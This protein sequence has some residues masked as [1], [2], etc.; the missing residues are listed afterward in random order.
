[1]IKR[2]LLVIGCLAAF[3]SSSAHAVYFPAGIDWANPSQNRFIL[4]IYLNMLG[5]APQEREISNA[6]RFLSPNDNSQARLDLFKELL[7][8]REYQQIFGAQ[9]N[10]WKVYR[11]PDKNYNNGNGYWRYLSA[12]SRPSG[13]ENWRLSGSS[14][15]SVA[16]SMAHYYD[17]F[18]YQGTPCIIDPKLAYKRGNSEYATARPVAHACADESRLV[19]QFEWVANNGTTYPRGTDGTTL[20]M[21]QHYFKAEGTVLQ[22][23]QCDSGYMN[24]QRDEARDIR[25]QR[26]GRDSNG[27]PTLFFA[28]G[29]RL[30]L[31]SHN[32]ATG[33]DQTR[34]ENSI[35]QE[36]VLVDS[37]RNGQHSCADPAVANSK[38]R[39][40]STNGTSESNGIGSST[41]CMDNFYYQIEGTNLKRFDCATGFRGCRANPSKDI[42]AEKRKRVE[43]FPGLEF[44]NGTTLALIK[45]GAAGETAQ[46]TNRSNVTAP[47]QPT[48]RRL[49]GQHECADSA[50][51]VSQFRWTKQSGTSSW[52]DGVA[53][54]YVCLNDSYYEIQGSTLRH[55]Q[56]SAN[57]QDCRA[58]RRNDLIAVS[59]TK[60][61]NGNM[62]LIFAN[63]D[64]LS[65]ISR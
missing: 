48:Q 30:V 24:C 7:N 28:D 1:M 33:T 41:V 63:G 60:D 52:P 27:K 44:S 17:T 22:R 39:W 51:R 53:G 65:L 19:S 62:T 13:F 54:R 34:T 49:A 2:L 5:R 36:P 6:S 40:R 18:C 46:T 3:C 8:N 32:P 10:L 61:G 59:D 47:A 38:F 15:E 29:T 23:F 21:G 58:N 43:G 56:C 14:S 45:K 4:S 11:A 26:T 37:T 42:A 16:A 25:G 55:H 20:C 50:L 9:E 31:T 57:Y 12:N 35:T 64:R